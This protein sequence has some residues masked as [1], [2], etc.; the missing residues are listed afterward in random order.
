MRGLN[1]WL[2]RGVRWL[3]TG[4]KQ[5]ERGKGCNKASI[6]KGIFSRLLLKS[7]GWQFSY[8]VEPARASNTGCRHGNRR[9]TEDAFPGEPKSC[10]EVTPSGPDEPFQVNQKTGKRRFREERKNELLPI[11]S[12]NPVSCK[13]DW[14]ASAVLNG[15]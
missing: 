5:W 4:R 2:R 8:A 9:S 10:R 14:E 12:E 7:F 13:G 3:Q 15:R 11:L 1:P 6:P